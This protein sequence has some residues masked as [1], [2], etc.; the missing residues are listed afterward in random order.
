MQELKVSGPELGRAED[1]EIGEGNINK[2]MENFSSSTLDIFSSFSM[3]HWPLIIYCRL[4]G[5]SSAL[6]M[7]FN[8]P[9]RLYAQWDMKDISLWLFLHSFINWNRDNI[10]SVNLV[11][12]D[13]NVPTVFLIPSAV[14]PALTSQF[15]VFLSLCLL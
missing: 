11:V 4:F 12:V 6:T 8:V 10:F 2:L 15:A 7:T 14:R 3:S 13:V 5:V 9:T 1:W